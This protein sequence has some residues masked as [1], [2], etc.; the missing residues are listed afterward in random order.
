M[1]LGLYVQRASPL[2][3]L[4]AGWKLLLLAVSGVLIFTVQDWRLLLGWLALTLALYGLARMGAKTTWAQVRPSLGLLAFF[5]V[6]Q[7]VFTNWEAGLVTVLRFGVM[8]L[9]ASLVTLTTRVSD[10]LATLERA[11]KPLA[12]FGVNPAKVSLAISLTLRFI[13]VIAQTVSDV[14]DAQRARGIEKNQLATAIPVIIRT[15]KMADDVADAI[16]ARSFD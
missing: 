14:Q 16:D 13:P 12:R 4:A 11:L 8:I 10:L 1:T 2:H 7:A 6:F 5:L 3:R 9:L 15:L